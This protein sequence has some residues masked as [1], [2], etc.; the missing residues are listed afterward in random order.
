MGYVANNCDPGDPP[1]SFFSN[2]SQGP[3]CDQKLIS[4]TSTTAPL[5]TLSV[6]RTGGYVLTDS[7][8]SKHCGD[9]EFAGET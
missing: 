8:E 3:F 6:Y 7:P 9:L 2:G 1:A 5:L 4:T